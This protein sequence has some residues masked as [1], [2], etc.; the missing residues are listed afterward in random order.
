MRYRPYASRDFEAL[1]AIEEIC[2][3]PP[4]RFP[5]LYMQRLL[6]S[7]HSATWIAEDDAGM[8]GFAIV[9]WGLER[10]AVLAYIQTIEV[11][12]QQRGAGVGS[13][14]LRRVEDSAG[15]AGAV[16]IWLHVDAQNGPGLRL[17]AARGYLQ[18]GHEEDY[19]APGQH[20]L[21]LLKHLR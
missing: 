5:R 4:L 21:I 18:A 12:P 1:Y 2:F 16:A 8:A 3:Q 9:E 6:G 19:Y 14:L 20:A 7:A 13:E 17:Y 10:E 15:G 11:I